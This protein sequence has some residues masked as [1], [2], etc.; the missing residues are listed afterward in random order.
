MRDALVW[1]AVVQKNWPAVEISRTIATHLESIAWLKMV[2]H[3]AA[4]RR[5]PV[6]VLHG[7][8]E[9]QQQDPA[10]DRRVED[11]PPDALGR[12]VGRALGLLGQVRRG[13]VAGDRVLGQDRRDRQHEEAG[14]RSR[15]VEPPNMPL[16]LMVLANTSLKLACCS[17]TRNR[18]RITAAA[19][20]T[21]HHTEMLLMTASRWL[22]KMLMIA[23]TARMIDEQDE[24]PRQAVAVEPGLAERAERQVEER[25][26]AVG[27]RRQDGDQADQVQP[28]GVEA[29]LRAAEFACPPVDSA[30][31]RETPRPARTCT[32]R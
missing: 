29:R 27:H 8:Q 12:A 5:H 2:D 14:S 13:V 1:Q 32:A 24:R 17:G 28:A 22:E 20:A 23:E 15:D 6:G 18:I 31:R 4:A 25:R 9:G 30:R 26:A 10:A 3:G 19:P 11:R 16:L 21:C 7:E